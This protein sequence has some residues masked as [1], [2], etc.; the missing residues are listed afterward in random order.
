[1]SSAEALKLTSYPLEQADEYR[2]WQIHILHYDKKI[3]D[4]V[5]PWSIAFK[6][7]PAML[8]KDKQPLP[9]T[10]QE[11]LL[12][13]LKPSDGQAKQDK[14]IYK[15]DPALNPF[16]HIDQVGEVVDLHIEEL[17][18]DTTDLSADAIFN[19]QL[20]HFRNAIEKAHAFGMEKIIFI[21]G[22]GNGRLKKEIRFLMARDPHIKRF[23]DADI[24]K[25]GY[26]ATGV[27]LK[28]T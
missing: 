25:F 11:G 13:A 4:I 5:Q 22:I 23:E 16:T 28:S 10:G 14:F 26:G 18:P 6:V 7:R 9:M 3:Q 24:K 2:N 27:Y 17:V 1:V 21:H 12:V 8:L 19:I 20:D 15:P